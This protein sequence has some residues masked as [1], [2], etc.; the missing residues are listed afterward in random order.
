MNRPVNPPPT[1]P[2]GRVWNFSA[3]PA[4]L[5][6]E[7]LQQA[8]HEMIDWHGKGLSVME[9]SHRS[10]EYTAIF[11]HARQAFTELLAIPDT[12]EVLFMQGGAVGQNA[13]VPLNLMQGYTRAAFVVTGSW[14]QKTWKEFSRYGQGDVLAIAEPFDHVPDCA[15]LA[16]RLQALSEQS[17]ASRPAYLHYCDNE[18]IGGVAFHGQIESQAHLLPCPLV[19]DMSSNILSG[20]L[21][22]S[23]LG[24]VYA[25]AQKTSALPGS[26]WWWCAKTC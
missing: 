6:L 7:V 5:P 24:L 17:G 25:G 19:A 2:L 11:Q 12:H 18:T 26:L 21:D 14:S 15:N 8:A 4:V 16:E 10:S 9:M 13:I 1:S 22:F 20:P 23:Q 3:G